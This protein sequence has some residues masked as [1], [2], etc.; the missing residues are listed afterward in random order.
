MLRKRDKGIHR[1]PKSVDPIS[2]SE[3][4]NLR[5]TGGHSYLITTQEKYMMMSKILAWSSMLLTLIML[6]HTWVDYQDYIQTPVNSAPFSVNLLVK[7]LTYGTTIVICL[8]L[9]R[10]CA[11]KA[12]R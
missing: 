11:R 8:V 5:N 10:V 2:S 12:E 6:F 4:F 9:A 1:N 3:E 7:G